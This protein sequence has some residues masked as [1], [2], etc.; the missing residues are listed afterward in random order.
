MP[1]YR[2]RPKFRLANVPKALSLLDLTSSGM[3]FAQSGYQCAAVNWA[4]LAFAVVL[5]S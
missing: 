2:L 3:M 5:K 1:L 4:F